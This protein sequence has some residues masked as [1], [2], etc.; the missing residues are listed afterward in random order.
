[1]FPGRPFSLTPPLPCDT[2]YSLQNDVRAKLGGGNAKDSPAGQRRAALRAELD[3]LR[4]RQAGSKGARGKVLDELKLLQEGT[5]RKVR[6]FAQSHGSGY[7]RRTS[8]EGES[9]RA[10]S[11]MAG[12]PA[13]R[14]LSGPSKGCPPILLVP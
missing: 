5:Q 11:R 1:M 10:C 6:G 14:Q 4:G 8:Q 12:H 9:S 13:L 2:L 7:D 3:E